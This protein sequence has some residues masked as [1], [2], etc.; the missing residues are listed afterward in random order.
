MDMKYLSMI[1]KKN[2][3][4]EELEKELQLQL[5]TKTELI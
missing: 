1:L 3:I 2:K 4:I 5:S